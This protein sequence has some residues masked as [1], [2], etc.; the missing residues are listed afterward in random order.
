MPF[1]SFLDD[2]QLDAYVIL[3]KGVDNFEIEHETY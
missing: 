2:I 1:F 3:K